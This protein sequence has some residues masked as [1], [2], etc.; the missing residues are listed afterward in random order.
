MVIS[1]LAWLNTKDLSEQNLFL[2]KKKLTII[3]R[4][5]GFEKADEDQKIIHMFQERGDLLGVPREWYRQ[6]NSGTNDEVVEV[7][8]GHPLRPVTPLALRDYQAPIIDSLERQ[9]SSKPWCGGLLEAFVGWGKTL[10]SLELCRRLGGTTVIFVHKEPL[11]D[12]W[13]E[14]LKKFFPEW[15]VGF[16]QGK[17]C[18]YEGKDIVIAMIQSVMKD[19]GDKYPDEFYRY[20]RTFIY[21]ETHHASAEAFATV[22]PR[23]H[24][25]YFLGVTGTLRR[26]DGTENVFYWGLGPMLAKASDQGR[27]KPIVYARETGFQSVR[28]ET[29]NPATGER[30]LFDMNAFKKPTQLNFLMRSDHR[31]D[32]IAYDVVKALQAGRNPLVM[33]ERLEMLDKIADRVRLRGREILGREVTTGMYIGEKSKDELKVAAKCEVV[34]ATSQLAKEGI[35]IARLDTLFLASSDGDPEQQIGR[36]TRNVPDKK[37]PMVVD[38]L[39]SSLDNMKRTFYSR[40]RLYKRLKWEVIGLKL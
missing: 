5:S 8:Q 24:A 36:V 3:P 40:L 35:D 27:L 39:D 2:I 9:M 16:V 12:Q 31:N 37:Q 18:E 4:L 26:K 15:K 14:V 13:I 7:S 11:K 30:R 23:F 21:D 29:V 38:Y 6:N 1:N 32:L 25:K 10:G 33:S 28:K 34:L 19:S 20:F 22:A 17:K